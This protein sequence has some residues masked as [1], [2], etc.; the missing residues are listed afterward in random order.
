ML[1]ETVHTIADHRVS[2]TQQSIHDVTSA[3]DMPMLCS[4]DKYAYETRASLKGLNTSPPGAFHPC[5]YYCNTA[6]RPPIHPT[7]SSSAHLVL[8]W[9]RSKQSDLAY[10]YQ[11][12]SAFGFCYANAR[13][14]MFSHQAGYWLL[15]LPM[16]IEA[17]HIQGIPP[18]PTRHRA[19]LALR[20]D[21]MGEP[22]AA[23]EPRPSTSP[24]PLI[25]WWDFLSA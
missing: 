18:S 2:L 12:Q 20:T 17:M 22:I 1:G 16:A 10:M 3:A 5:W 11:Y 25:S 24:T 23:G 14:S 19:V 15:L 21:G 6:N 8:Y 7:V 9:C 13:R 4:S